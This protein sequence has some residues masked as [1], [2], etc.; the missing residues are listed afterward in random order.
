MDNELWGN[1]DLFCETSKNQ[2]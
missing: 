1:L 2:L